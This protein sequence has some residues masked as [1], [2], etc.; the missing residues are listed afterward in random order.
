MKIIKKTTT[1]LFV[2]FSCV[3]CDQATKSLARQ[4]L[5][6]IEPISM[7]NDMFRFQ[8]AENPGAFLSFGA[9]IPEHMRYAIFTLLIGVFLLGLLVH[10]IKSKKIHGPDIIALSL[11]L[12]GGCGN[13]IDRIFNDGRVVDFL[14]VGIGSLRTGIF[15]VADIA[16]T[17]GV[18]WL[19]L[20]AMTKRNHSDQTVRQ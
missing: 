19:A 16:I 10:L 1:I 2:L 15:N 14:N 20:L 17:F 5:A 11:V 7:F 12:G 8:Y 9:N 18:I 3:G 4:N 13:L 6:G